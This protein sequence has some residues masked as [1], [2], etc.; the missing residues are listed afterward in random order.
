MGL[1][2]LGQQG[3]CLCQE[4]PCSCCSLSLTNLLLTVP[5]NFKSKTPYLRNDFTF[6]LNVSSKEYWEIANSREDK[7]PGS[8]PQVHFA[9]LLQLLSI[10]LDIHDFIFFQKDLKITL[11]AFSL[12]QQL[13]IQKWIILNSG[14]KPMCSRGSLYNLEKLRY[15]QSC[16]SFKHFEVLS[17]KK[18]NPCHF[19]C[20]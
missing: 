13:K 15:S 11:L 4:Q 9:F 12:F 1:H 5:G 2:Q 7:Q 14:W 19:Q 18:T 6:L 16:F 20:F 8:W 17:W 10:L 3:L